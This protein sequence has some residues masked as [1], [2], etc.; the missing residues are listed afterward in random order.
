MPPV[1]HPQPRRCSSPNP[2]DPMII[3]FYI[4]QAALHKDTLK[5][6]RGEIILDYLQGLSAITGLL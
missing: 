4:A 1:P 3:L 2:Q 6:L 5:I